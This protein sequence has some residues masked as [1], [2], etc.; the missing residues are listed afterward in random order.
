MGR[1]EWVE[2]GGRAGRK[3]RSGSIGEAAA[4]VDVEARRWEWD[5]FIFIFFYLYFFGWGVAVWG[6]WDAL[7]VGLGPC[8]VH[9]KKAKSFQD[10]PSH[11]ILRHMHEILNIDENKN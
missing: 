9:S 3:E 7:G 2:S 8:L 4:M 10:F 1:L 11:R 6:D 5:F